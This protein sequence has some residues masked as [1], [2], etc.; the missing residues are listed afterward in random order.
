MVSSY[1][2]IVKERYAGALDDEGRRYLE[3]AVDGAQRMQSMI[4]DLLLYSRVGTRGGAF[5][6]MDSAAA[7]RGALKDLAAALQ[8]AGAH[9]AL[10]RL[11]RV[12]ADR[13]QMRQVFVNLIGNAVK[14]QPPGATPQ[15]EVAARRGA[16]EWVFWVKDN[17]IG[18]A[19][20]QAPRLFAPFRRLHSQE[21]FP[22]TGIGLSICRRI[23]ERRGGQMWLES[24]PGEG[25]TFF[26]T[27]PDE[28]PEGGEERAPSARR[29]R[30]GADG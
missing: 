11:P 26:F 4:G 2:A 13:L 18:I 12:V 5:V 14:F 10:G 29:T 28:V 24:V 17:G 22:G 16:N 1:C 25:S 19:P 15:V 27:I 30:R 6:R 23:V 8:K 9:V 20:D 7:A 3:F 21:E